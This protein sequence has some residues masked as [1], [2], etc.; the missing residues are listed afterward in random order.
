MLILLLPRMLAAVLFP[1]ISAGQLITSWAVSR[2]I[3]REKLSVSQNIALVLGTVAI[4][5]MNL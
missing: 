1:V 4:V 3:C 2:F 5:L